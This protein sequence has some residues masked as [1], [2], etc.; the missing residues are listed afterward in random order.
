LILLG[1]DREAAGLLKKQ[2]AIWLKLG[3]LDDLQSSYGNQARILREKGQVDDALEL[4]KK[5]EQICLKLDNRSQLGYCYWHW[6]D[7]ALAKG[8]IK[9]AKSKLEQ[10]LAIFTE[11]GMPRE[12][13]DIQAELSDKPYLP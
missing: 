12:R 1:R 9:T 2:E 10:A 7:A 4:H 3:I 5:Q 8:A 13:D 6:A 11:L